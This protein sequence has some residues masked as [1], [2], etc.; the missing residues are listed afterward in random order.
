MVSARVRIASLVTLQQP[1]SRQQRQA[2]A[3]RQAAR[4][5]GRQEVG[6]QA[7]QAGRKRQNVGALSVRTNLEGQAR[8]TK[9]RIKGIRHVFIRAFAHASSR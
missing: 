4:E 8:E 5:G 1:A 7:H 2:K 9:Q 6:R 3:A